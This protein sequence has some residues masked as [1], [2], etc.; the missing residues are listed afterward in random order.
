MGFYNV[1]VSHSSVK[2]A[3]FQTVAPPTS[4]VNVEPRVS[5]YLSTVTLCGTARTAL[6]RQTAVGPIYSVTAIIAL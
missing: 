6:M 5:R 2:L 4:R 3:M 1:C